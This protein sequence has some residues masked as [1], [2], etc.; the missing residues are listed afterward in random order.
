MLY[1]YLFFSIFTLSKS[2]S[3]LY[4]CLILQ[5]LQEHE[6]VVLSRMIRILYVIVSSKLRSV[7]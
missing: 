7:R 2:A 4:I 3:F 6:A 1:V 5:M